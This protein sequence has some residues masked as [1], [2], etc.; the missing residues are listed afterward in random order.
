MNVDER[1]IA[2]LVP[3]S[4][5]MILIDRLV[6]SAPGS[7]T[8]EATVR[9]DGIFSD[10]DGAVSATVGVEY[11]AQ[12][13][14]AYSGLRS[15]GSGGRV[16]PGLLLGVRGYKSPVSHFFPGDKLTVTVRS[17]VEGA[18]GLGVFDCEINADGLRISARLT[19]VEVD[20][21]DALEGAP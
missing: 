12:T 20:S 10:D 21:L 4:G 18:N 16:R 14:S 7:L 1:D 2:E 8:A 11:M 3:H 9:N 15:L 17:V 19:V 6:A 13:I 5:A